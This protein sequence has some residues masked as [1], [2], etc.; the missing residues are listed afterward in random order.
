MHMAA[1]KLLEQIRVHRLRPGTYRSDSFPEVAAAWCELI[2]LRSGFEDASAETY[3]SQEDIDSFQE[4]EESGYRR[5]AGAVFAEYPGVSF[6]SSDE[7]ADR[8]GQ[9]LRD[10]EGRQAVSASMRQVVLKDYTYD[11]LVQKLIT[12][13][14]ERTNTPL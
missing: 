6:A 12:F 4:L 3:L 5:L 10:D 8:A 1:Q 11:S 7:F 2:W 9:F 13:I 14:A